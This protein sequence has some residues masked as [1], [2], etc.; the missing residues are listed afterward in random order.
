V[1]TCHVHVGRLV[2]IRAESGYRSTADVDAILALMLAEMAKV[3]GDQRL[4]HAIDWRRCPIMSSDAAE[5]IL[6]AIM[7]TNPRLERSAVLVSPD[8]STAVL[9]FTRLI[10]ESEHPDR[11]I[12]YAAEQMQSWLGEILNPQEKKRL[13]DFLQ[14]QEP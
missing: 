7:Q 9:Q 10:R 5:R 3:P 12:F 11:L 2:E 8:S 14:Y 1:N 6:P 13:G 4:V